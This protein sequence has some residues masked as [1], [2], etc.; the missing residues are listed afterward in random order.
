MV[1][2]GFE[3]SLGPLEASTA[4]SWLCDCLRSLGKEGKTAF[5]TFDRP[6]TPSSD[7]SKRVGV[8]WQEMQY[9]YKP[10]IPHS[11]ARTKSAG[12]QIGKPSGSSDHRCWATSVS[13]SIRT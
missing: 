6:V 9:V 13:S 2:K 4:L 12:K 5:A 11:R 7:G 3:A 1:R 8:T 10:A